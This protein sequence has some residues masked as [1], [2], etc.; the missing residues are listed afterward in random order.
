MKNYIFVI[1][2]LVLA[3]CIE[4]LKPD[5][6]IAGVITAFEVEGQERSSINAATR[7]VN[8]QL[9]DN[10]ADVSK[11]RISLVELVE[12][13][14]CGLS[15]GDVIDLS[16]P[17]KVTV[18]TIAD[19]VWTISATRVYDPERPLPGGDFEEWS[20]ATDRTYDTY[21]PWDEGAVWE[22]NKWWDTGNEGVNLLAPSNSIPTE[23]GEGCPANP[24]GRAAR[25]ESKWA[26]LKAAGGNIYFGQF[27]DIVG[28]DATCHLGHNWQAKPTGLK[29]WY[30]Y[31]PQVIDAVNDEY[32]QFHPSDF[33]KDEWMGTMDSLH[34]CVALW[35]S[36]DGE[37]KPF[38][39]DTAPSRFIDFSPGADGVIA[40]GAFVSGEE[41][42]TWDE[43]SINIKYYTADQMSDA[44]RAY[45]S[46][47]LA[48]GK[49][50]AN[51]QLY[52]MITASKN[53]NYFIAGTGRYGGSGSLMY[54]DEVELEYD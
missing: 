31:F 48:T 46:D 18:T 1:A 52:L 29:G 36:P 23:P 24:G 50:P 8:I 17:L 40:Y 54:V 11:V 35:A 2:A 27:G 7:T 14:T 43:F 9:G 44:T 45:L 19:Y 13:A 10:V 49:L 38:T 16:A 4:P 15:V 12:T 25:L 26:A 3:S 37:N 30:K 34:V 39:V 51:T 21:N 41:Q 42:A 53:C 32:L 28:L 5:P 22:L 20:V 33:T 47:Y 6:D